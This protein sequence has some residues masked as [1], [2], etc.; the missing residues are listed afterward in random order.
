MYNVVTF[1]PGFFKF[2]LPISHNLAMYLY[3]AYIDSKC[4]SIS[5]YLMSNYP[6]LACRACACRAGMSRWHVTHV[7][8]LTVFIY[9]PNLSRIA[10]FLP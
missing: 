6:M 5:E 1:F 4:I 10:F 9:V 2:S 8:E 3:F 7:V